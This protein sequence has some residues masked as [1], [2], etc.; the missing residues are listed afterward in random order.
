MK[1]LAYIVIALG[2]VG[3]VWAGVVGTATAD[4]E[5]AGIGAIAVAIAAVGGLFGRLKLL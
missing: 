3:C 4:S 2:L 1:V 5:H